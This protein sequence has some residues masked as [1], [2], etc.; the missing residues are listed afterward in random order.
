MATGPGLTAAGG[1]VAAA[2]G[3]GAATLGV[4]ADGVPPPQP[5]SASR[6]TSPPP[7]WSCTVRAD[8]PLRSGFIA[9]LRGPGGWAAPR[10][11]AQH[12]DSPRLRAAAVTPRAETDTLPRSDPPAE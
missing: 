9:F 1:G 5:P 11:Q 8:R 4:G 6:S 3:A 10:P 2:A 7:N 12:R